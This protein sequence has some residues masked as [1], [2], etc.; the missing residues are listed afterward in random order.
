MYIENLEMWDNAYKK[1]YS[2]ALAPTT[3]GY[4]FAEDEGY[5]DIHSEVGVYKAGELTDGIG[6]SGPRNTPL[7]LRESPSSRTLHHS[8]ELWLI[9][10]Q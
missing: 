9:M 2:F 8:A 3:A 4:L 7:L 6:G 10:S 5:P 1:P